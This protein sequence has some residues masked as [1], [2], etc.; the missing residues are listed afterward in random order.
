MN[1]LELC[2]ILHIGAAVLWLGHMFFWSIFAGVML[3]N[4][5][6]AATGAWL[7]EVSLS[8]GGL[9]WPSL[10]VLVTTGV[11]VLHL[12]GISL[13]SF[14]SADFY[15]NSYGRALGMKLVVVAAMVVYQS[16]YGH[17]PA[18]SAVYLNMLAA[19]V[20][21]GLGAGLVRGF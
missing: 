18:Q 6:P 21:V 15:S 19:L 14:F 20:V 1:W 3:K 5:Q 16:I 9:G 8:M 4:V 17:R 13:S 12:R 7:R 10:A 11:A 2:M